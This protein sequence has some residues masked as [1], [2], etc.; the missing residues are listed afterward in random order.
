MRRSPHQLEPGRDDQSTYFCRVNAGK[1]SVALD[2]GHPRGREVVLDLARHA[3]VF[4]ENFTPGVV[5]KLGCDYEAVR[6]V[7]PDIV[8]CSI[9]GFTISMASP[10]TRAAPPR[11]ASA[12][13]RARCSPACSATMTTASRT[14]S[15]PAPS[16]RRSDRTGRH[17]FSSYA[18]L[19]VN[20]GAV[21]PAPGPGSA[22]LDEAT[23]GQAADSA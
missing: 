16:R 21:V 19:R 8:Y 12:S 2:L 17:A 7:K 22:A 1:E 9:S 5:A 3:D 4:I 11:T 15:R 20:T 13:T 14:C 18:A 10:C 23:P 6:A